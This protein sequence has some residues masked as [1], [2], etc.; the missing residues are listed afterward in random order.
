MEKKG[1]ICGTIGLLLS[2][3][4]AGSTVVYGTLLDKNAVGKAEK[5]FAD[6]SAGTVFNDWF[7]K[8]S[9]DDNGFVRARILVNNSM[10][11][12]NGSKGESDT[13]ASYSLSFTV[14]ESLTV[15]KNKT[16]TEAYE[17]VTN[18]ETSGVVYMD[19]NYT[20]LKYIQKTAADTVTADIYE[21]LLDKETGVWWECANGAGAAW[22]ETAD[23]TRFELLKKSTWK[24][25]DDFNGNFYFLRLMADQFVAS[26]DNADATIDILGSYH[27]VPAE[28]GVF[29]GAENE[30]VFTLGPAPMI[31]Y[32]SSLKRPE[33]PVTNDAYGTRTVVFN[34]SKLNNTKVCLPESLEEAMKQ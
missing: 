24:K 23:D 21:Y 22:T 2:L 16:E 9:S 14:T 3:A 33:K 34:Y 8:S 15:V 20:Y 30:C 4:L 27:F 19:G 1:R 32:T 7:G 29:K 13:F 5:P 25:S 26:K 12:F 10:A 11:L 17:S 28:E 31:R 18:T 6:K